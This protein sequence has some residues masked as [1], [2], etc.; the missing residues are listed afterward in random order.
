MDEIELSGQSRP[1]SALLAKRI[2]PAAQLCAAGSQMHC[3]VETL[4]SLR[5]N[6]EINNWSEYF[7]SSSITV[8]Y[9]TSIELR[10]VRAIFSTKR[11]NTRTIGKQF[12]EQ[13]LERSD[14]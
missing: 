2:R 6:K 14:N 3:N 8:F 9:N 4:F 10:A 7:R 5:K 11:E 12:R 1:H 13:N